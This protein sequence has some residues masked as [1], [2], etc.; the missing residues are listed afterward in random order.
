MASTSAQT[1]L[2]GRTSG[3]GTTIDF[4]DAK[5]KVSMVVIPSG[6]VTEGIIAMEASQDNANWVTVYIFDMGASGVQFHST[7]NGAFRYWRG[8]VLRAVTGGGSVTATLM[9]GDR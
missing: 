8:N 3:A 1:T 5:A 4:L 6:A 2:S 9:E 7:A